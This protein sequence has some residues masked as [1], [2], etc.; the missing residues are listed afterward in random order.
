MSRQAKVLNVCVIG[1][2]AV[3][4]S[5]VVYRL[6]GHVPKQRHDPTIEDSY[7]KQEVINGEVVNIRYMDTSGQDEYWPLVDVSLQAADVVLV[8][9]DVERDNTIGKAESRVR[10]VANMF[11][12][13]W[14]LMVLVANKSD[15]EPVADA[16][17]R[18]SDIARDLDIPI[19]WTSAATGDGINDL[20]ERICS[21][22]PSTLAENS[23][24]CCILL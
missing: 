10:K 16:Q 22:T 24:R 6:M 7:V 12:E 21:A 2:G 23:R 11:E 5:S 19:V 8:V 3:G 17:T 14:P 15:K 1:D 20:K 9:C 4:K 18:L 13:N